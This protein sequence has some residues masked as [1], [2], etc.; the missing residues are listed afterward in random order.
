[1]SLD[2]ERYGALRPYLYHVT[3]AANLPSLRQYRRLKSAGELLRLAGRPDHQDQRR[4]GA[5]PVEL[6]GLTVVIRD[7]LRIRPGQLEFAAGVDMASFVAYL[8]QWVF[9]W[10]G[11]A[12]RPQGGAQRLAE[13]NY[14]ESVVILRVPL[15]QMLDA[16]QGRIP[17]FCDRNSG[18]PRRSNGKPALRHTRMHHSA[19]AFAGTPSQVVE[20]AFRGSVALPDG[21]EISTDREGW[22]R[23]G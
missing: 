1:M 7:Q 12:V 19:G 21:T 13:A 15:T 10:P 4:D 18:C 3:N 17:H 16:N 5:V 22:R 2:L 9:F 14:G 8:N 23:F 11:D 6:E 20:V